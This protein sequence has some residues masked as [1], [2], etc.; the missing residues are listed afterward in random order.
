MGRPQFETIV[1]SAPREKLTLI[2]ADIS[3]AIGAGASQSVTIYAPPKKVFTVSSMFVEA[4]PVGTTG[5]QE[6]H[7][8]Y[9]AIDIMQTISP[10]N[11]GLVFNNNEWFGATTK[12]PN[13]TN[14]MITALR[15]IVI[16]ELSGLILNYVNL[17]NQIQ[18]QIVKIRL[19]GVERLVG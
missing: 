19:W 18:N 2:N 11:S 16:D 12:N 1:A 8:G 17:T 3:T 9:A 15:G 13:D 10:F 7:L 5:T 4:K 14:A 6:F